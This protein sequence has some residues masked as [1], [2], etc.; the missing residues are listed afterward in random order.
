M[1]PYGLRKAR[2]GLLE[3]SQN[4]RANREAMAASASA[5]VVCCCFWLA[6]LS[7]VCFSAVRVSRISIS[8]AFVARAVK[9]FDSRNV[10]L[11]VLAALGI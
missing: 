5:T 1:S 2:S 4:R 3:A 6:R 8:C 9:M 7:A 11:R 10:N